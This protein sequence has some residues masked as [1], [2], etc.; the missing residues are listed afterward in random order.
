MRRS[1]SIRLVLLGSVGALTLT[2]C[3]EGDRLADGQ[4]ITDASQCEVA[5]DPK[6]CREALAVARA[7]HVRTAPS[8]ASRSECEAKFGAGNCATRSEVA[9]N[10]SPESSG[11]VT[12]PRASTT[13]SSEGGGFFM[14][15]LM[16]Y[17]L[18]RSMGG[19]AAQPLYRDASNTAYSGGKNVG[20]VDKAVARAP[21]AGTRLGQPVARGGFGNEGAQ[22]SS[23]T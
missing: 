11:G 21:A 10:A 8:F 9:G 12:T 17:M 18:G 19:A 4:F 1:R 23:A 16:G 22:R 6:E 3:D 20:T 2:A 14:P 5:F 15:L 13:A 7:E